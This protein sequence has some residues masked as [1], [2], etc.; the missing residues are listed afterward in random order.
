MRRRFFLVLVRHSHAQREAALRTLGCSAESDRAAIRRAYYA[1]AQECHPDRPNGT[2]ESFKRLAA[3]WAF[4]DNKET[5]FAPDEE[6]EA[7]REEPIIDAM[8]VYLGVVDELRKETLRRELAEAALLSQ[9]G[10]DRGGEWA[11]A[12]LLG[13]AM[14]DDAS[15]KTTLSP[16]PGDTKEK[17]RRR[18]RGLVFGTTR[19]K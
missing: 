5:S 15:A 1:R 12:S 3:A 14:D 4:L 7:P 13:H 17:K 10:L 2:N 6:A 18:T 16:P 9:G 8:E 11:M 19:D